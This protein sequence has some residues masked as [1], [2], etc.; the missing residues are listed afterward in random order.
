MLTYRP[1]HRRVHSVL[2]SCAV[3]WIFKGFVPGQWRDGQDCCTIISATTWIALTDCWKF[4]VPWMTNRWL[5]SYVI[6]RNTRNQDERPMTSTWIFRGL[7][8]MST[9]TLRITK[10]ER[11]SVSF[12]RLLS[13]SGIGKIK[14]A[15]W[16]VRM[17]CVLITKGCV[18]G[19]LWRWEK[20][21]LQSSTYQGGLSAA[22][23]H[24]DKSFGR[25]TQTGD[26]Q[27]SFWRPLS[28]FYSIMRP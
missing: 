1:H 20:R 23:M 14:R 10:H 17:T 22:I 15:K 16:S 19:F 24:H 5:S 21:E 27:F 8:S 25:Q 28:S 2:G 3:C 6:Q 7:L 12:S 13:V 4:V 11:H 26:F 9:V 18:V